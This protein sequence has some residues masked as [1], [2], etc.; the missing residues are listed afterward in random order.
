[1]A[2]EPRWVFNNAG[3]LVCQLALV[4]ASPFEYVAYFGTPIGAS[5]FFGPLPVG[6][7]LGLDGGWPNA[8][9]H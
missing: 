2:P 3:N 7:R 4:Y 8:D 9:L 6:R 1:M 5:G